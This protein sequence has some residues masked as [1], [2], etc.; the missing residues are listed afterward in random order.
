M[1]KQVKAS[2]SPPDPSY[3][4]TRRC[5]WYRRIGILL[6]ISAIAVTAIFV[7]NSGSK[8]DDDTPDPLKVSL[9]ALEDKCGVAL[10]NVTGGLSMVVEE[11]KDLQEILADFTD[12]SDVDSRHQRGLL[13]QSNNKDDRRLL[14]GMLVRGV[15]TL[16]SFGAKKFPFAKRVVGQAAQQG[17]LSSL[18]DV[19]TIG[20]TMASL[21]GGGSGSD[22]R[23]DLEAF[24]EEFKELFD[25]VFDRFDSID[26]Q[27]RNIQDL[28]Q[29]GFNELSIVINEGFAK[30]ELDN[31]INFH[32]KD[33]MDDYRNYMNLDHTPETRIV[34][35]EAFRKSCQDTHAPST[36]FRFLYSNTCSSC[37]NDIG[38]R[39][40]QY[41]L[42]TFIDRAIVNFPT[43]DERVLW[44][45]G[46][47]S[48]LMIGAMVETYYLHSMCL[49]QS[50]N[51]CQNQDPVWL[52]RLDLMASAMIEAAETLS[53]SEEQ[54]NPLE[55][56]VGTYKTNTGFGYN[57]SP[58]TVHSD[59]K[60]SIKGGFLEFETT[61]VEGG[62]DVVIPTQEGWIPSGS[63]EPT[64][65]FVAKIKFRFANTMRFDGC[66]QPRAPDGC[67]RYSG[68]R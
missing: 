65:F 20:S 25:Q 63:S 12:L 39:S 37:D 3:N 42:D 55:A 9:L 4:R 14:F 27:L 44:F 16:A 2:S 35:E 46:S 17:P 64:T 51:V 22:P 28:I 32:L 43:Y 7:A 6:V 49:Y 53:S 45:R 8:D 61:K 48:T 26:S 10:V 66:I 11:F 38:D 36:I 62:Y 1:E 13:P 18:A 5:R 21:F 59:A 58:L 54:L 34:Y 47:Y 60:I 31:W 19:C 56:F 23:S 29:E 15:T 68:T 30:Q 24:K 52:E 57:F 33:L 67:V 40:N 41:I 50:A